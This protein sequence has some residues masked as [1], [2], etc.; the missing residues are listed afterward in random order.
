MFTSSTVVRRISSS[1]NMNTLSPGPS[2]SHVTIKVPC[3]VK[4]CSLHSLS[5]P[6]Q[7]QVRSLCYCWR[8]ITTK[9]ISQVDIFPRWCRVLQWCNIY[10]LKVANA[11]DLQERCE[12]ETVSKWVWELA[13]TL[14]FEMKISN[15][16]ATWW[17]SLSNSKLAQPQLQYIMVHILG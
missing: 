1:H 8:R 16:K 11:C 14:S 10:S 9:Y 7:I 15:H 6:C 13:C 17:I 12:H 2:P 5:V 4:V 3:Q